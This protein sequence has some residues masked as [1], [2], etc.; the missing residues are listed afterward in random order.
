MLSDFADFFANPRVG[1]L[2]LVSRADFEDASDEETASSVS[3]SSFIGS[4]DFLGDFTGRSLAGDAAAFL[5]RTTS[6]PNFP[7]RPLDRLNNTPQ[8]LR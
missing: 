8:F 4:L 3:R 6:S 5:L 7:A 1:P 2:Y